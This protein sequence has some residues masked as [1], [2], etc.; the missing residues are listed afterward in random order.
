MRKSPIIAAALGLAAGV[1]VTRH[2]HEAPSSPWWDGRVGTTPLRRSDLPLGGV[3]AL[4]LARRLRKAGRR[5]AA[6]TVTGLGLGAALGA[7]GTGL[8]DP[9]PGA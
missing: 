9:L 5:G 7:V 1:A 3:A 4:L 8:M 2:A 6:R